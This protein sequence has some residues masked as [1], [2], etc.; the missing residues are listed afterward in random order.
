MIDVVVVGSVNMDLVAEVSRLPS[1]GE[2]ILG[3]SSLTG[4][5]GKGGNQAV[6]AQ[7]VGAQTAL[8]AAV[9]DDIF[10]NG[11]RGSI[12]AEGVNVDG[13]S[14]VAGAATGMALIV[15]AADGEN[16]IVVT[17]GANALL[18][19]TS[20]KR[21]SDL[22][23]APGAVALVQLE[24]PLTTCLIAAHTACGAG[25]RVVLNC[26]PTPATQTPELFDLL[27][28]TDVLVV[29][30]GEAQSL[31]RGVRPTNIQE[32]Q[33]LAQRLRRL[34][35]TS[36]IITLGVDGAVVADGDET[37]H[38]PGFSVGT[39]D[40]TGAGDSFCAALS[41]ALAHEHSLAD[42]VRRGCAAGALATTRLGAQSALPTHAALEQLLT[43][44]SVR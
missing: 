36:C 21:L 3:T 14:S 23:L 13:V 41:T 19:P 35:P 25:V 43:S 29:N 11:V 27:A 9:G 18:D 37:Y 1:P 20:V 26:A 7:R 32:W 17:P 31:D 5:G 8:F 2:T 6:A 15:V 22:E 16:T 42:A 38:Q 12:A 10:G 39:V 28:V 34:G 44:G 33:A 4:P 24:V 40:T 30:Q